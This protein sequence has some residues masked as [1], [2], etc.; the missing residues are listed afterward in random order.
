M[1]QKEASVPLFKGTSP[2]DAATVVHTMVAIA[3][4][5]R[6]VDAKVKEAMANAASV[7]FTVKKSAG[8]PTEVVD[9]LSLFVRASGL[10]K[11]ACAD[12][13]SV[14]ALRIEDARAAAA[15]FI[16]KFTFCSTCTSASSELWCLIVYLIGH[17]FHFFHYRFF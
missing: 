10:T 13:A 11:A 9:A 1:K 3:Q 15:M 2:S 12:K 17:F 5:P 7:S 14:A 8:L 6:S 4:A 16:G